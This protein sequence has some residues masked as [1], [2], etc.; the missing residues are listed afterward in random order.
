MLV[1][2]ICS[3]LIYACLV[4]TYSNFF[5]GNEIYVHVLNSRMHQK[6][7]QQSYPLRGILYRSFPHPWQIW[8]SVNVDQDYRLI[9]EIES[10]PSSSDITDAFKRD[11][12]RREKE[13]L[14]QQSAGD[15]STGITDELLKPQIVVL[16]V[17]MLLAVAIPLLQNSTAL[18]RLFSELTF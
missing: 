9:G 14:K 3:L 16:A 5:F 17:A 10:N 11:S 7:N 2:F 1:S 6:P 8:R 18:N 4:D 13:L 12:F 15:A